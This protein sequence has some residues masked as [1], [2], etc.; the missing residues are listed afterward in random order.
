MEIKKTSKSESTST[1]KFKKIPLS[2]SQIHILKEIED[3]MNAGKYDSARSKTR[4]ALSSANST[5]SLWGSALACKM[6]DIGSETQSKQDLEEGLNYLENSSDSLKN[7]IQPWSLEYNLANAKKSLF[8]LQRKL[9]ETE[10]STASMELLVEAKNSYWKSYKLALK[11]GM[12]ESH[13]E[14]LVNL[15]NSLSTSGRVTEALYYFD[16]AIKNHSNFYMAHLNRSQTLEWL[17]QLSSTWTVKHLS[18]VTKGY[19]K[20]IEVSKE[21]WIL[22][23]TQSKLERSE[24][25]LSRYRIGRQLEDEKET[26]KEFLSLPK[27]RQKHILTKLTLNEHALYCS[28]SATSRDNL[29]IPLKGISIISDNMLGKMEHFLNR[30]KAEFG[31]A[32]AFFDDSQ[33]ARSKKTKAIE[34]EAHLTDLSTNEVNS[35]QVELLRS[36]FR[37][38]IGILDKIAEAIC[39]LFNLASAEEKVYFQ[40]FWRKTNERLKKIDQ[41]NN[42]SLIALYSQATDL[43]AKSGEWAHFKDWRNAMEHGLFVVVSDKDKLKDR[44]ATFQNRRRITISTESELKENT[45][46]LLQFTRSAIFNFTFCAREE[47]LRRTKHSKSPSLER[48][49]L[50][51]LIEKPH[52]RKARTE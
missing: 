3:L 19:R 21:R 28:C 10:V 51:P 41:I 16:A 27:H 35:H 49:E 42:F 40:S 26:K 50:R 31:T 11:D 44:Y 36:S 46:H 7:V 22:E 5:A 29:T 39:E 12:I 23:S 37:I 15:A 14:I 13:P 32:R 34:Y 47:F 6:I 17:N 25:I 43:N 45:E 4:S 2:A 20:A 48:I 33:V 1:A 9:K 18:E 8:N 24:K 30:F 38:C 52:S